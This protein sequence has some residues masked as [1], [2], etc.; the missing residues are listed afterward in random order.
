MAAQEEDAISANGALHWLLGQGT[1]GPPPTC[2]P[3]DFHTL[4]PY[5]WGLLDSEANVLPQ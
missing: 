4:E 3:C 2:S 5:K 1:Q